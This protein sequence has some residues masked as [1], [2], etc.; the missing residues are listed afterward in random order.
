MNSLMKFLLLAL[1]VQIAIGALA[2]GG[3]TEIRVG[4][5]ISD[6]ITSSD[7]TDDE[8]KSKTYVVDVDAGTPYLLELTTS[9]SN[10][11]GV[12]SG[13]AQGYIL[14]VSPVVTIRSATY[15]FTEGGSQKLFI[16]SP[17]SDVPSPFTFKIKFP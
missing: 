2:C 13:D 14:Q 7:A 12:W 10:T 16:Q 9:N 3:S 5:L 17:A 6:T 1:T 11:V 8:W 15:V 4:Q